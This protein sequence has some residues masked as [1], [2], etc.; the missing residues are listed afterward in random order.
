LSG[1]SFFNNRLYTIAPE[2]NQILRSNL[3][4]NFSV[5][6][7]WLDDQSVNLANARDLAIDGSIY[8]LHPDTVTEFLTGSPANP[9]IALAQIDPP[10]EN[11]QSI[12]TSADTTRLYI[13]DPERLLVYQ[14]TG[15]FI[16]QYYLT[17][18]SGFKDFVVDEDADKVY[19]LT[20]EKLFEISI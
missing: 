12:W 16:G 18:T 10:L 5:F 17:D 20:E 1:T 8:V 6:N 3:S 13:L 11:A 4:P 15:K 9:G 2:L 19:L 14:K 7:N